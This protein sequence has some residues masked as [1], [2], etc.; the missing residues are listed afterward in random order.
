MKS[1]DGPAT[2]A[3]EMVDFGIPLYVSFDLGNPKVAVGMNGFLSVFPIVAMPKTIYEG[4]FRICEGRFT[5][6]DL[7]RTI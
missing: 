2:G 7:R 4:R 6:D 5:N 1:K 3:V